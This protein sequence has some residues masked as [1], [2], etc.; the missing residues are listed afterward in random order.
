MPDSRGC[1]IPGDAKFPMTP[2]DSCRPV[3][4][5]LLYHLAELTLQIRASIH[6]DLIQDRLVVGLKDAK[7]SKV[8]TSRLSR[9]YPS[10]AR[11]KLHVDID[12]VM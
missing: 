8:Q 11:A 2:A 1:Q 10:F 5:T 3:E 6:N 4:Y 7:L 12:T 9:H